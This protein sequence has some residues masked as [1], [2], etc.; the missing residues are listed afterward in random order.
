MAR[1]PY[2]LADEA[3]ARITTRL[4]REFRHNRLA[5]F[6]EMN[7]LSTRKHVKKLY[8]KAYKIIKSEFASILDRIVKDFYEEA[9]AMGFDGDVRDLDEAWIEEFFSKYDRVTKY[10]FSNEIERKESRLFEALVADS[11]EE[12]QSYKTAEKLLT[13]QAKQY[14]DNFEDAVARVVYEDAG[15][16][17]VKWV[18]EQDHKTCSVCNELDGEIFPIDAVPDK[19][20]YHCRCYLIPVQDD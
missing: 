19:Q 9:L 20:H 12:E 13:R 6:D 15:V 17:K 4:H 18:A 11:E 14:A 1:V 10:V 16:K 8:T 7:V 3:A 5:L 2:K